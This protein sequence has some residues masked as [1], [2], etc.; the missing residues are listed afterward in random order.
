MPELETDQRQIL[1]A[2]RQKMNETRQRREDRSEQIEALKQENLE[3]GILHEWLSQWAKEVQP[4][5]PVQNESNG[6]GI[7]EKFVNLTHRQALHKIAREHGGLLV[8][9]DAFQE[10]WV[11]NFFNANRNNARAMTYSVIGRGVKSGEWSKRDAGVYV[12][13]RDPF[14]ESSGDV[15]DVRV[16]LAEG[17]QEATRLHFSEALR[18]QATA[19]VDRAR[20]KT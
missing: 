10:L 18:R 5:I 2:I 20:G 17:Q 14:R 12:Q 15:N 6:T 16:I 7:S 13:E 9:K 8:M 19:A 11:A 1:N 4:Q 3:D